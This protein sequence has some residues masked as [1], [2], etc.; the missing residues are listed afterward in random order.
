MAIYEAALD[1]R[2]GGAELRVLIALEYHYN[3][4]QGASWPSQTTLARALGSSQPSV[5]R[6]LGV[7]AELGYVVPERRG[8]GL[9]YRLARPSRPSLEAVGHGP[10]EV[11]DPVQ[12]APTAMP[13]EAYPEQPTA[14]PRGAYQTDPAM[15]PEAYLADPAMPPEACPAMPPGAWRTGT[16]GTGVERSQTRPAPE[17]GPDGPQAQAS[18]TGAVVELPEIPEGWVPN[19]GLIAQAVKQCHMSR[20][21]VDEETRQF[22][23]H[24]RSLDHRFA[25]V[26]EAWWKWMHNAKPGGKFDS[27]A[28]RGSSVL[29]GSAA[30]QRPETLGDWGWT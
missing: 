18:P 10:D 3:L 19:N 23:L 7:L 12:A 25:R 13:P 9:Q 27:Q 15:P 14:M 11:L 21:A 28:R 5:S 1:R 22:V 16:N 17:T 8:H 2:L 30:Q 24:H 6:R 29:P 4:Q 26:H 20:Q